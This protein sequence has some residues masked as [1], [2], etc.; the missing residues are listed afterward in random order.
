MMSATEAL[1]R[2]IGLVF[3]PCRAEVSYGITPRALLRAD[4]YWP[5]RPLRNKFRL[6]VYNAI[7]PID[8]KD[9]VT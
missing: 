1:N 3:C 9:S 7:C 8:G 4:D 5:C 2:Q 6:I